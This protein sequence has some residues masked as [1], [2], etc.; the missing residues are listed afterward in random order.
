[1]IEL[2]KENNSGVNGSVTI[3]SSFNSFK[4]K[5]IKAIYH[6]LLHLS[7]LKNDKNIFKPFNEGYTQLLEHRY[8]Y[9]VNE[10]GSSYDFEV[11]IMRVVEQIFGKDNIE[12][13]YFNGKINEIFEIFN[14]YISID[15]L[16][17]INLKNNYI[18]YINPN[19]KKYITYQFDPISQFMRVEISKDLNLFNKYDWHKNSFDENI[20]LT[21][22]DINEYL[23]NKNK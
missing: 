6:E 13:L 2:N 23:Y 15:D 9:E 1:M 20:I 7:S 22:N 5:N 21:I 16:N 12:K 10:L 11:Y 14:N 17:N 19:G 18:F 8:F 4:L 3:R